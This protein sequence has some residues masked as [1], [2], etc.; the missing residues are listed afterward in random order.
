[1]LLFSLPLMAATVKG[2]V[3]FA[4]SPLPGA[5]VTIN[6]ADTTRTMVTDINGRFHF[7]NVPEGTCV[8]SAEI[9]G[10]KA[11]ETKT[12]ELSKTRNVRIA[13]KVANEAEVCHLS[14]IEPRADG[15]VFTMYKSEADK[16]PIGH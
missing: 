13:M 4:G 11:K 10:L 2:T 9:S 3:V 15:A 8:V 6:V 12:V 5:T 16:L 1:M 14:N 7:E